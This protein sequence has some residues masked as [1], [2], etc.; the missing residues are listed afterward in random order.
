MQAQWRF[1]CVRQLAYEPAR[2]RVGRAHFVHVY[3]A[4]VRVR[5]SDMRGVQAASRR[6]VGSRCARGVR[7]SAR[8]CSCAPP[9]ARACATARV[10][11]RVRTRVR[12]RE[13]TRVRARVR[14]RR[15]ARAHA[16]ARA[17][18]CARA[19]V[20]SEGEDGLRGRCE[21]RH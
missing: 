13:R 10:R 17:C 9:C 8:V 1:A 5:A 14:R 12:A 21:R 19:H 3:Y 11:A 6:V 15:R 18:A 2:T 20:A 16:R 7:S 4:S